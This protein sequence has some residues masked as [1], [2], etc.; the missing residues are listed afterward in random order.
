MDNS[1]PDVDILVLRS[2][3][4]HLDDAYLVRALRPFL[5]NL[6]H[7]RSSLLCSR[8]VI[9]PFGR[10]HRGANVGNDAGRTV[11]FYLLNA[12]AQHKV[13]CLF[14]LL[15]QSRVRLFGSSGIGVH[16]QGCLILIIR[17]EL[18]KHA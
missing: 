1:G 9:S 13:P 6:I 17:V 16:F 18:L 10:V 7:G 8:S 4:L 2:H 14:V 5:F 12:L 15:N 11:F 3:G